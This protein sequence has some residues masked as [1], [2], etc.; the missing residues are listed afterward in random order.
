MTGTSRVRLPSAFCWS[1]AMPRPTCSWWM[2]E[3][4]PWRRPSAGAT[5]VEFMAG[6]SPSACDDGEADEV[7]EADLAGRRPRA[8][9]LLRICRLTSSSRAGTTRKLVAV[10]T[11]EA[12]RHVGDDPGGRAAAAASRPA[13]GRRGRGA[14]GRAARRR[15]RAPARRRRVGGR[16][17]GDAGAGGVRPTPGCT[18]SAACRRPGTRTGAARAGQVG[19]ARPVVGE[20]LPPALAHRRRVL[21][22]L[23]VHLVDQPGVRAERASD[24]SVRRRLRLRHGPASPRSAPTRSDRRRSRRSGT[25]FGSR[26]PHGCP[27]SSSSPC[28]TCAASTRP[29]GRCCGAS[30]SRSTPGAKI[31]VIGANGSGKSSLLRIMAGVDDGFTGEARLTPGFT[32]GLPGP[33][34]RPRRDQGRGRQR[35][36]RGGRDQGPARPLQR[37]LRRPWATP[38]PTSTSCWPSRPSCRTGSTPPAPGIWSGRSRSPW[39]P[40][41]CRPATPTS[42][43]CRAASAA[44]SR[45]AAS[46]S[47]A[48]PAA[49]RRADQPPRRRVGRLARADP[50]GVPRHR[51][52]RHPR[53]VLPRQRRRL[54]PRARP[55]LRDPLGGQLLVVAGAEAGPPGR[56]RRRPTGPGSRTLERELEWIR[57]VAPGPP[58]QGQGADQ[59]L[60]RPGGR[61]RGGRARAPTSWRSPSRPVP[62]SGDVVVEATGWSRASATAC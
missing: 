56:S 31:G 13:R 47:R 7:G 45:C 2:T 40:S 54:D 19:A 37:G 26:V 35:G 14:G 4:A 50:A 51:R 62:G 41:A 58:G 17:T 18:G 23:L 27:S 24:P 33:G 30:T 53:P 8:S 5:N 10:G 36:R 15:R 32:V 6:T 48:R 9:W 52:R 59:R 16:R 44:G 49:A 1:T 46:C 21:A 20:E 61:G 57:H 12:G 38:T 39:T 28:A 60:Q 29:T 22:V 55:R 34:A 11:L 42:P 25:P 3:P 43:R